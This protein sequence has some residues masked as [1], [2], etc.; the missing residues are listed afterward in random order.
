MSKENRS[1]VA[2]IIVLVFVVLLTGLVTAFFS[3]ATTDRQ[4]AAATFNQVKADVL[5]RSATEV[6]VGDLKQEIVTGTP[7]TAGNIAPQRSPLPAI[8]STPA[9]PNLIRRSVR[10]DALPP[11]AV[12]SRASAVNSA[13]DAPLNGRTVSLSRWNRHYLVPKAN[14]GN[15]SSDPISGAPMFASPQFWAP[16]WGIG[17]A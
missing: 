16:D 9:I 13:T 1:G 2:L 6:I 15:D 12:A 10:S 3:R 7:I 14:T 5:A 11:P 17:H 8:G 4:L